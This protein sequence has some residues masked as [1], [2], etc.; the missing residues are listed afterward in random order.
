MLNKTKK[1]RLD[2]FGYKL[3]L[4][5]FFTVTIHA[6]FS[7]TEEHYGNFSPNSFLAKD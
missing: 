4:Q 6:E 3:Q 1:K 2:L 7:R 5:L